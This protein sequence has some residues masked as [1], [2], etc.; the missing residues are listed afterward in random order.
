MDSM[1][2]VWAVQ[3][4]RNFQ[5]GLVNSELDRL[6]ATGQGLSRKFLAREVELEC[7]L[8]VQAV[9]ENILDFDTLFAWFMV[10]PPPRP[11]PSR[12]FFSHL[13]I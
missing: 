3:S 4:M 12:T 6:A 13:P 9:R 8:H 2:W 7:G 10:G 5:G 1:S 11:A